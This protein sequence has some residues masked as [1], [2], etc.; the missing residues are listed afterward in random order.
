MLY[1]RNAYPRLDLQL[2]LPPWSLRFKVSTQVLIFWLFKGVLE[3]CSTSKKSLSFFF[4]FFFFFLLFELMVFNTSP[5]IDVPM[6]VSIL[7]TILN[8]KGENVKN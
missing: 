6:L 1:M 3:R 4:L 2:E 5:P 7:N 8:H